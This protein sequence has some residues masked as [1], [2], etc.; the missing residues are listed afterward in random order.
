MDIQKRTFKAKI[1]NI[2]KRMVGWIFKE[3][4]HFIVI[5]V[6][7]VK[8]P[9]HER[10]ATLTQVYSYK[11]GDTVNVTMYSRNGKTW[12]FTQDEMN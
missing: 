12:F 8:P 7:G 2:E 3:E 11:V 4:E 6:E 10:T 9:V 1:L 5:R